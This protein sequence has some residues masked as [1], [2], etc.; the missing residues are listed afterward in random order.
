M[1]KA[2]KVIDMMCE[3]AGEPIKDP[4]GLKSGTNV[5]FKQGHPN[6]GLKGIIIGVTPGKP[7]HLDLKIGRQTS[8]GIDAGDLLL[9][10]SPGSGIGPATGKGDSGSAVGSPANPKVPGAGDAGRYGKNG[11]PDTVQF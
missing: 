11:S 2:K 3:L 4:A 1:S 9:D 6:A 5:L 8:I 10:T 7:G